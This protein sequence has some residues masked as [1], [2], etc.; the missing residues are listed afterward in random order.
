LWGE[1]IVRK[2]L[3]VTILLITGILSALSLSACFSTQSGPLMKSIANTTQVVILATG[4]TNQLLIT[5]T[6]E[7]GTTQNVTAKCTYTI[8]NN[9]VATISAGGLITAIKAGRANI[10]V[11]YVSSYVSSQITV[12]VAVT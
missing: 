8:D 9:Q 4:D 7:D 12:P 3:L 11:S 6:F 10:T 2:K 1:N 5:A